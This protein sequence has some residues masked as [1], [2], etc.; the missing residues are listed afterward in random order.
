MD[1]IK[2]LILLSV[3][4]SICNFRCSYC[5]LSHRE[6]CYQN[7]QP[8]YR[9]SPEHVAKALSPQ[10]LGGLAY[11]NIC[12]DGETLLTKD[13]DKYTYEFLKEGHYVEFVTNLTITPVLEKMLAW[14][15]KLL[16]HLTFKCS[17]HYLQLR[18]KGLLETFAGNVQK[19]WNAGASANIEITPCDEMIPYLDEIK[20]FSVKHFG[21]L[22][23]LTIA[24]DD[25]T[26]E[27]DYLTNLPIEQYDTIWS[28]FDSDFWKF[29]KT[30]FKCKRK[31][32]C[33]AGDWALHIDL[34]T[35]KT[36]GCYKGG[37]C[38][39]VF[40]RIDQPI[41]FRAIGC[42]LESHCYNGHALLTLGCIPRFTKIKYGDI[43]NRVKND[44]SEWLQPEL[45]SFFNST[46]M[47]SNT[48]YSEGRKRWIRLE[49]YLYN[50][51]KRCAK[52]ML[53]KIRK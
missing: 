36:N 10:R 9:Y 14:D 40:E 21:A 28:Q 3:P 22:P 29:K 44:G 33:Y 7:K 15:K 16:K 49:S 39:N 45:K 11:I 52:W 1:K 51:P 26:A 4:M 35:G 46:L 50:T 47:E 53:R 20:A 25:K 18:E 17:F 8:Q 30:I 19:I 32:F 48:E 37:I 23:H 12:A 13:I 41:R 2:R 38:Q 5:Y 6:E 24:R 34:E 43:R 31:E 27:M 42:C